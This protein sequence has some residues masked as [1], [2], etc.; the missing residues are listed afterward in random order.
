M[1]YSTEI[2]TKRIAFKVSA[3]EASDQKTLAKL[4]ETTVCE[5]FEGRCIS[6]GFVKPDSIKVITHS[7]GLIKSNHTIVYDVSFSCEVYVPIEGSLITCRAASVIRPGI[8][9]YSAHEKPSPFVAFVTKDLIFEDAKFDGIQKDD[10]FTAKVIAKRF[11]INDEHISIIA[12][13][14]D[15]QERKKEKAPTTIRYQKQKKSRIKEDA[16]GDGEETVPK[17]RHYKKRE[18]LK[19]EKVL[20]KHESRVTKDDDPIK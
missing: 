11:E 6:E 3:I 14:V 10:V 19:N 2:V 5:Q 16:D 18:Q 12:E 17:K 7:S 9:A 20:L 1:S 13:F 4:I 8:R 15:M